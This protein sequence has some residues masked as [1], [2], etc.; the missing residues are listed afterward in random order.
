MLK[1]LVNRKSKSHSKQ[2]W[3]FKKAFE[4]DVSVLMWSGKGSTLYMYPVIRAVT[5][6]GVYRY[7]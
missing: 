1:K 7:R 2:S 3:S 5:D 6:M 4:A